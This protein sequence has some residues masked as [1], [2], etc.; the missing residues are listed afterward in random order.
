MPGDNVLVHWVFF[1]T[2]AELYEF[3]VSLILQHVQVHLNGNTTVS[4]SVT[5][6]FVSFTNW[7][8]VHYLIFWVISE[9]V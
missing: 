4:V 9:D 1:P 8:R 5:P 7:Q 3:I 6:S 2:F